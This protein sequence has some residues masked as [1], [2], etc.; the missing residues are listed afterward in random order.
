MYLYI[1]KK[2]YITIYRQVS[3]TYRNVSNKYRNVSIMYQNLSTTIEYI[4]KIQHLGLCLSLHTPMYKL[5]A[6][7]VLY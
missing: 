6:V 1:K 7:N 5:V 4:K 2:L 3:I